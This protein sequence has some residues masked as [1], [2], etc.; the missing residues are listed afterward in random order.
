MV[1]LKGKKLKVGFKNGKIEETLGPPFFKTALSVLG[2]S[3][4]VFSFTKTIALQN[5]V[6][7]GSRSV[8]VTIKTARFNADALRFDLDLGSSKKKKKKKK[9]KKQRQTS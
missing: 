5:K 2:I 7:L 8:G 1:K 9:Q 4:R 3:E 6:R